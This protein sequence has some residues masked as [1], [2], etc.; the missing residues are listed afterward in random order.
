MC[1]YNRLPHA[2]LCIYIRTHAATCVYLTYVLSAPTTYAARSRRS[3]RTCAPRRTEWGGRTLLPAPA[4]P[5]PAVASPPCPPS[6]V[7]ALY[8]VG[9]CLAA[10]AV[11]ANPVSEVGFLPA[12]IISGW[13]FGGGIELVPMGCTDAHPNLP[14]ARAALGSGPKSLGEGAFRQQCCPFYPVVSPTWLQGVPRPVL[15]TSVRDI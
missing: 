8:G 14:G 4:P 2:C 12:G 6:R 7:L 11:P 13:T 15:S 3:V 5:H 10:T 1:G 9:T